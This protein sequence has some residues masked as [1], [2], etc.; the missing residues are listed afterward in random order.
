MICSECI[1]ISLNNLSIIFTDGCSLVNPYVNT[2]LPLCRGKVLSIGQRAVTTGSFTL[3]FN[4]TIVL[5][6]VCS[7][8]RLDRYLTSSISFVSVVVTAVVRCNRH[9][10]AVRVHRRTDTHGRQHRPLSWWWGGSRGHYIA[11]RTCHGL[12][13]GDWL[14]L[15]GC[16]LT[17]VIVKVDEGWGLGFFE[18]SVGHG[19]GRDS[20]PGTS[21]QFIGSRRHF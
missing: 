8:N 1:V 10:H 16:R 18:C 6:F 15:A 13:N 5:C 2:N 14:L 12:C 17:R 11:I 7:L 21:S 3:Y 4:P 19:P 9:S 20:G